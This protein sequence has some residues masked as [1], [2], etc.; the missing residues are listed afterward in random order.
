MSKE[1]LKQI[2]LQV[3]EQQKLKENEIIMMRYWYHT[4]VPSLPTPKDEDLFAVAVN[5]LIDEGKLIYESENLECLRLTELGMKDLYLNSKSVCDIEEDIL[6]YFRRLKLRATQCIAM[7]TFE[8]TYF[9]GLNPIEKKRY[10]DA[11][12]NLITKK[13]VIYQEEG[14]RSLILEPMGEVYI[15]SQN[16]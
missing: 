4:F 9:F 15:Y 13:Y 14:L 7:R 2:I 8:Q 3:Y 11:I 1:E 10:M 16:D 6:D 5:E 12:N